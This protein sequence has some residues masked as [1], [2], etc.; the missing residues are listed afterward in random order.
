MNETNILNR[1]NSQPLDEVLQ[2]LLFS[3]IMSLVQDPHQHEQLKTFLQ[4]VPQTDLEEYHL[5]CFKQI[6][7]SLTIDLQQSDILPFVLNNQNDIP[8]L[9]Q[10]LVLQQNA[11]KYTP[12]FMK[13]LVQ[14]IHP[15]DLKN[16]AFESKFLNSFEVYHQ[17]YIL[18]NAV[19]DCQN[20]TDNRKR[21]M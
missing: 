14:L 15:N 7:M 11:R 16:Y 20:N 21:K 9:I 6:V 8:H 2:E 17:Q 1:L 10:M 12:T 4:L 19:S 18:N 5:K 3:D 13:Q